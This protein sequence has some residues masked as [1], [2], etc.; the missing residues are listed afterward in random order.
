MGKSKTES[1]SNQKSIFNFFSKR[2]QQNEK[3][4]TPGNIQMETPQTKKY[5]KGDNDL[6]D[7]N[8]GLP[9]PQSSSPFSGTEIAVN[10]ISCTSSSPPEG[11]ISSSPIK[12]VSK[13]RKY[14]NYAHTCF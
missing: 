9:T 5:K 1:S 2:P 14:C 6:P 12:R 13:K 3:A 11:A 8:H 10:D 4:V 7:I